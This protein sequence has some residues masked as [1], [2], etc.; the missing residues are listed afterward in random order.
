MTG[1]VFPFP[2]FV[3]SKQIFVTRVSVPDAE[4][5]SRNGTAEKN[6]RKKKE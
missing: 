1:K 6:R 4:I 2:S 3:A 5:T